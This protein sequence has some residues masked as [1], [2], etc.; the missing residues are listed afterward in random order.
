[1][2]QTDS[3]ATAVPVTVAR[4]DSTQAE[5]AGKAVPSPYE[6]IKRLPADATPSQQDS[7]VQAS[8]HVVN[9]HLSTR[10]D[11][12]RLPLQGEW[13]SP[14]D[15]ELPLYYRETFF[16][17]DSLYHPEIGGGRQGIAGDPVPYT[18][19]GDSTITALLL[20]CFIVAMIAFANTRRFIGRQA[21]HF[22]REPRSGAAELSETTSEFRSQFF[23]MLLTCLLLSLISFLYTLERVADTFVLSSQYQLLGIFF[24]IFVAYFAIRMLVYWIVNS[25]FFGARA[26]ARWLKL[27]LFLTSAEGFALFPSVMLQA[28]F[29]MSVRNTV[30]YTALVIILVKIL[31]F[32]KSFVMF[33]KQ[34]NFFLQIILYFCALEIM[35]LLS[36]VGVLVK[37]V[38]YLKINF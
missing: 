19:R 18:V 2:Q 8:L 11:T 16:A 28:Y 29:D 23:F 35:P 36:L 14:R 17:G 5:P 33:F 1:M 4:A 6:I 38:D 9:T 37:V 7:A 25:V 24:G 13:T 22:F 27:L 12:L 3:T 15:A 21:R 26:S 20:V 31:L 10:P 34:K 30:A 32:Y